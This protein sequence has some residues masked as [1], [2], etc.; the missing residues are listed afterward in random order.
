MDS[1]EQLVKTIKDWIRIDNE[2]KALQKEVSSRKVEKKTISTELMKIMKSNE[3][4]CF[5]INNGQIIYSK[6]NIK[7]PITKKILTDLLSKYFNGD[8]LKAAA[9]NDYIIDNRENVVKETIVLKMKEI[10]AP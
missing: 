8:T 5:D 2:L 6:K 9:I 1:R 10:E 7:K 3:I 4:D